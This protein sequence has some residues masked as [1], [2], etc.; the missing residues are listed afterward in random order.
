MN[1]EGFR[2]DTNPQ[3][4][5]RLRHRVEGVE[6]DARD[7]FVHGDECGEVSAGL[8]REI[9]LSLAETLE[10]SF[11]ALSGQTRKEISQTF[12][13]VAVGGT[14]RGDPALYSDVDLLFLTDPKLP[15]SGRE[16]LEQ[17]IRDFWDSGWKLGHSVRT[18]NECLSTALE[19]NQI[20]TSLIETRLLW[21]SSE[22]YQALRRKYETKLVRPRW[23]SLC[24]GTVANRAEERE[25]NGG[26]V[27][28]LVPDVKRACGGLR[29][30]H[31]VRWLTF[32]EF[33][34]PDPG[35]LVIRSVI[36]DSDL[37]NVQHAVKYL[38]RIRMDLHFEAGQAQD[39]LTRDEQLRLAT[40][41]GLQAT[42]GQRPV[43][44]F[45]RQYFEHAMRLSR[46]AQRLE[47]RHTKKPL[48]SKLIGLVDTP[49]KE[50]DGFRVGR[51]GID[52]IP[53]AMKKLLT[54]ADM[55]LRLFYLSAMYN[56]APKQELLDALRRSL[57][58]LSFQL[59]SEGA[60]RFRE[61]LAWSSSLE[62]VLRL[63]NETGLLERIVPDL[64]NAHFLLQFNQYHSY[65]VDEHTFRA[66][67][68][69]C[70][71]RNDPGELGNV[72]RSIRHPEVVHLAMLLHDLGKGFEE[73]HSEVGKRI[74]ER[75]G[76]NLE[77][78]AAQQAQLVLL[79]HKHLVMPNTAFWRDTTD[80]RVLL[81]F[82]R[83][84]GSVEN[85]KMLYVLVAA[86]VWAVGPEVW[87]DWKAELLSGLYER[88]LQTLSGEGGPLQEA[89]VRSE[90]K[91]EIMQSILRD[92]SL[93]PEREERW[94]EAEFDTLPLHYLL[95]NS[96]REIASD[97]ERVALLKPES[98]FVEG[99]Y[100]GET[101]S[102]EY[103][104]F[105]APEFATGCFHRIAGGL[106]A[107]RME[108]RAAHIC[109]TTRGVVVDRFIV[110]DNDF[111]GTVP[112]S[113]IKDVGRILEEIVRGERPLKPLLS[114]KTRFA[115]ERDSGAYANQPTKLIIDNDSSDRCTVVDVFTL[116]RRGLLHALSRA[117]F[118]EGFSVDLARIGTHLEQ[119]VDVFY[120]TD[121]RGHKIEDERRLKSLYDRLK[122]LLDS[123]DR[124]E[125]LLDF[126]EE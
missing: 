106:T 95:A 51:D 39:V 42:A 9:D 100:H 31:F 14:G 46:L 36:T 18:I 119:V 12:A 57:P 10:E 124:G 47:M 41:Y 58:A 89:K 123:L 76:A 16:W 15:A 53:S 43:E 61:I 126:A 88:T 37:L 22:L 49:H 102:V 26:A 7:R 30:W 115:R 99:S 52:V 69:L 86:D 1:P 79:V 64:S 68:R 118:E 82:S 96:A 11:V 3:R 107:L 117:I 40:K 109:T 114:K 21:G 29:D 75:I 90:R 66:I 116:D 91:R 97:L 73:D 44:R 5:V 45:M 32:W 94:L 77:F 33:G 60:R 6:R 8:S 34:T 63:M 50:K 13:L 125:D 70:S 105:L 65:T 98:V 27:L 20:A 23:K 113:R 24:T 122:A 104:I 72:Y 25:K 38:S 35:E 48:A 84:V 111:E 59:S 17:V 67:G 101:E 71:F 121:D 19:D 81:D 74:A 112:F 83:E 28:S 2:L 87:T 78:S 62:T 92:T 120:L 80:P 4:L 108:I 55:M 54:D 110:K 56:Q 103:R 93:D 85:L